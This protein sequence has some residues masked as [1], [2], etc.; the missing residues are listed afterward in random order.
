MASFNIVHL[1]IYYKQKNIKS[2]YNSN[3]VKILAPTWSDTFDL[4]DGSYSVAD[5]QDYFEFIIRN[6]KHW[7]KMHQFKFIQIKSKTCLFS[8]QKQA[9]N[10]NC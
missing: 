10:Y 7:Q 3:T 9:T 4:Q 5:I 1:N 8:K 2:E 6:T